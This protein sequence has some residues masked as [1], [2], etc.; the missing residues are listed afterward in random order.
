MPYSSANDLSF[1]AGFAKSVYHTA[2][3]ADNALYPKNLYYQLQNRTY[4]FTTRRGRQY[5]LGQAEAGEAR[6]IMDNSD[7]LFDPSNTASPL[8]GNLKPYRPIYINTAHNGTTTPT[9]GNFINDTNVVR[10]PFT[11][12]NTPTNAALAVYVGNGA[13]FD[14]SVDSNDSNAESSNNSNWQT[15]EATPAAPTVPVFTTYTL[16][17]TGVTK[18]QGAYSWQTTVNA[19][20][21]QSYIL[22]VPVVPGKQYVVSAYVSV[23]AGVPVMQVFDGPFYLGKSASASV[24]MSGATFTRYSRTITP[25]S[26]RIVISFYMPLSA[27][28]RFDGV[29]VE[30]G[31]VASIY[32]TTGPTVGSEFTGFVERYPQTFLAPNRGNAELV[33]TDYLASMSQVKLSNLYEAETLALKPAYYYPLNSETDAQYA[34]NFS[35]YNQPPLVVT[36]AYQ[37]ATGT[38]GTLAF[39]SDGAQ[40][41]IPAANTTGITCVNGAVGSQ[42]STKYLG[43]TNLYDFGFVASGGSSAVINRTYE[44]WL[45]PDFTSD[46]FVFNTFI[47]GSGP[48]GVSVT[49]YGSE[50]WVGPAGSTVLKHL[51][52]VAGNWYHLMFSI[53]YDPSTT[54]TT[55]TSRLN[56][57]TALTTTGNN[58]FMEGPTGDVRLGAFFTGQIAHFAVYNNELTALAPERYLMGANALNGSLLST[59]FASLF[60]VAGFD[61]PMLSVQDSVSYGQA[62]SW[63]GGNQLFEASQKV[64]DSE[65][66]SWFVTGDGKVRFNNR[67][68]R[69]S[70]VDYLFTFQDDATGPQYEAQQITVNNDPTFVLNDITVTRQGGTVSNA[71]DSQ[72]TVDYFPRTYDRTIYNT[73]DL[74]TIDCAFYLLDRYKNA[75]LRVESVTLTPARNPSV[76]ATALNVEIDDLVLVRKEK[77][78]SG[79]YFEFPSFVERVENKY[80]ATSGD[81]ETIVV[82]SPQLKTYNRVA[83]FNARII[84]AMAIGATSATVTNVRPESNNQVAN[85][86]F[87]T[88]AGWSGTNCSLATSSAVTPQDGLTFL[89]ATSTATA[90][91]TVSSQPIPFAA[92]VYFSASA[93]VRS[94]T[95]TR[96]ASVS[97]LWYTSAGSLISTSAGTGS[98]T[99]TAAWQRRSVVSASVSPANT[100]YAVVQVTF[101]S[102]TSGQ[103]NYVDAV[104]LEETAT[105]SAAATTYLRAST[106][107]SSEVMPGFMLELEANTA[108][109]DTAVVN[110]LTTET[111]STLTIPLNYMFIDTATPNTTT[112]AMYPESLSVTT[113]ADYGTGVVNYLIGAEIITGEFP[114]GNN[115]VVSGLAGRGLLNTQTTYHPYGTT[116]HA[117]NVGGLGRAHAIGSYLSDLLPDNE[118]D[119]TYAVYSQLQSNLLTVNSVPTEYTPPA[120]AAYTQV[121]VTFVG[122]TDY[123][124]SPSQDFTPGQLFN[125]SADNFAT[126]ET[127]GL[128]SALPLD[129]A[130]NVWSAIFYKLTG[131]TYLTADVTEDGTTVTVESATGIS[132][133]TPIL[134]DNE[135]FTVSVVAGTT[136]TVVRGNP[137]TLLWKQIAQDP[138]LSNNATTKVWY[139]AVGGITGTYGQ[140]S[141]ALIENS[142]NVNEIRLAY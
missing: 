95:V 128:V 70:Q 101:N 134:I 74:E 33:A 7:G 90:N 35:A 61:Y 37:D 121:T 8:Y 97:V 5:E 79:E 52:L 84:T 3:V 132:A 100:A 17:R 18:W 46:G 67:Q 141:L 133:G 19:T 39:G 20:R 118:T 23:L 30:V 98:T 11:T 64:A 86:S 87:L 78:L 142:Q 107:S 45:T 63:L 1:N 122:L 96:T 65:A 25:V 91:N 2:C 10:F 120:G 113:S 117:V 125:V 127:L 28:V 110:G 94:A 53:A 73:S 13:N 75:S 80:D 16:N 47:S 130:T 131:F 89:A 126:F 124:N 81:W 135:W 27:Q 106:Y 43:A 66:A 112:A 76:W 129:P 41:G 108:N 50:L 14:L 92:G 140:G 123:N 34:S 54:S 36:T 111:A 15:V 9:T 55:V 139:A 85:S 77:Y 119:P 115:F 68:Y 21:N 51:G 62:L 58:A 116:I 60:E 56:G 114:A 59:Q 71:F 42:K 31:S 38:D 104:Q 88:T 72:S 40:L 82:V 49:S 136:L 99:S 83:P 32:T 69:Q 44:M 105:A 26:P 109:F 138:H 22:D 29:Q 24:T 4:S 102:V 12:L 6:L 57:G 93:Y 48:A 137:D 103:V